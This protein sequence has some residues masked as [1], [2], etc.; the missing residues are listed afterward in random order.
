MDP[1]KVVNLFCVYGDVIRVKF[2]IQI[3]GKKPQ[4]LS[5][6][7]LDEYLFIPRILRYLEGKCCVWFYLVTWRHKPSFLSTMPANGKAMIGH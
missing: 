1:A 2:L 3:P 4:F 7:I 5:C 6:F